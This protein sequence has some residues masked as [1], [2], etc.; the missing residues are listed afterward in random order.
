VLHGAW[1]SPLDPI[2]ISLS[3]LTNLAQ[4]PQK[5]IFVGFVDGGGGGGVCDFW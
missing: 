3:L 5:Q 1:N 4:S 2:H